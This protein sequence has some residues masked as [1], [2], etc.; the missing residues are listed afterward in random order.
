[1]AT[2]EEICEAIERHHQAPEAYTPS[3]PLAD[4]THVSEVLAHALELGGGGRVPLLSE[5]AMRRMGLTM[6]QV[7]ESLGKVEDEYHG[8]LQM[9]SLNG[10]PS[11]A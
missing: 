9:L 3:Y 6:R 8:Y 11:T 1:M 2:P 5:D 7:Q 10:L 4:L